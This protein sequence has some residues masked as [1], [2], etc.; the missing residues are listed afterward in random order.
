L[1]FVYLANNYLDRFVQKSEP[2][3]ARY[4]YNAKT[5]NYPKK[6]ITAGTM[7]LPLVSMEMDCDIY[8]AIASVTITQLYKNSVIPPRNLLLSLSSPLLSSALTFNV[9]WETLTLMGILI[10]NL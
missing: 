2:S 5:P 1:Y 10:I 4:G 6:D 3:F 7:N 9:V 8:D